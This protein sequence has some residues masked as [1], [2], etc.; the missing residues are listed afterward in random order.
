MIEGKEVGNFLQQQEKLS[1]RVRMSD[2]ANTTIYG[3]KKKE[4]ES[5]CGVIGRK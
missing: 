2:A 5:S 3:M 1:C 4:R